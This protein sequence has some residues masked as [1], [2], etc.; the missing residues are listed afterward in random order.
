M[1][2]VARDANTGCGAGVAALING[3]AAV[4]WR[5]G[6][7]VVEEGAVEHH[8]HV[9]VGHAKELLDAGGC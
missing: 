5:A 9:R 8:L 1:H 6:R 7:D 3:L 4:R 2:D